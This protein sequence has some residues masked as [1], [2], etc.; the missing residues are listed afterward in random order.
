MVV[1][2]GGKSPLFFPPG[3][4]LPKIDTTRDGFRRFETICYDPAI[5][6]QLDNTDAA[7]PRLE[8]GVFLLVAARVRKKSELQRSAMGGG[9]RTAKQKPPKQRP[10]SQVEVWTSPRIVGAPRRV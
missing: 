2:P 5:S 3:K 1:H 6:T 4:R 8:R 9:R 7:F 10:I